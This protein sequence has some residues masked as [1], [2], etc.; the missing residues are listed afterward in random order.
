MYETYLAV[1]FID[2][3]WGV[4]SVVVI[5]LGLILTGVIL[6]QD[7]KD[8]GIGSAFGGG[9]GGSSLL[10][11]GMQKGIAKITTILSIVFALCIFA[12]GVMENSQRSVS[13][14][15]AGSTPPAID[16]DATETGG[17]GADETEPTPGTGEPTPGAGG[18]V[19]PAGGADAGGAGTDGGAAAPTSTGN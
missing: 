16:A 5:F 17:E 3:M 1:T 2:V 4:L 14:G 13:A 10:G 8:G 12:M 11:A 19:T 15:G 9:G 6:I 18:E 7:S